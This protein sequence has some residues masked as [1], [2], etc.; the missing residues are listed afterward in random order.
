M[1]PVLKT[2]CVRATVPSCLLLE[3]TEVESALEGM[4]AD[5]S[6]LAGIA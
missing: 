2:S 3:K 6:Q 4:F 1:L 5:V